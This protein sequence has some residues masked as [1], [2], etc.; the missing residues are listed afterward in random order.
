M[1][2]RELKTIEEKTNENER[3]GI[4]KDNPNIYYVNNNARIIFI[5]VDD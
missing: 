1:G 3:K 4:D 5:E 2:K